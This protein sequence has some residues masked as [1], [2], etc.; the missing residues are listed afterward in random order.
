MFLDSEP[1]GLASKPTGKPDADACRSWLSTLELAGTLVL[2]PGKL[3]SDCR[4]HG[5]GRTQKRKCD[6]LPRAPLEQAAR[7]SEAIAIRYG[8]SPARGILEM[9]SVRKRQNRQAWPQFA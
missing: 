8:A 1:L 9:A 3:H 5:A 2:I 6:I 4:R 7:E